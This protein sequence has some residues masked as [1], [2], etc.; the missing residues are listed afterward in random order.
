MVIALILF[1]VGLL[2]AFATLRAQQRK[3]EELPAALGALLHKEQTAAEQQAFVRLKEISVLADGI[4]EYHQQLAASLTA[5]REDAEIRARMVE[6][7]ASEARVALDAA[8][9]LTGQ[10]R[11]VLDQATAPKAHG[12][13]DPHAS[14]TRRPPAVAPPASAA[15]LTAEPAQV[16]AG[17]GPRPQSARPHPLP[18]RATLL[19][20][21]PPP[22]TT[23]EGDRPSEEELT[24]VV[25]RPAPPWVGAEKTLASMPAV[26]PPT[27]EGAS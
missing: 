12:A 11:A 22:P 27:K 16:A 23:S 26:T 1:G 21:R 24:Q 3:L 18:K 19:G 15:P 6:R 4:R 13:D 20:I 10:L 14:T 9:Q 8:S 5:Q 7:R 2:A 25:T 17:L